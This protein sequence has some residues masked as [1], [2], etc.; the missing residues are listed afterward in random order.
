MSNSFWLNNPSILVDKKHIT[1]IWPSNDLNYTE[2]LNAITRCIIILAVL[3][4]LM[5]KSTKILVSSFITIFIIALVYKVQKHK[6]SKKKITKKLLKEGFTNIINY[7]NHNDKFKNPTGKNP[8][9]NVMLTEI[10][11]TPERP[12]AAPS[13]NRNI[14]KKINDSVKKNIDPKLFLDLGDS[15]GFDQSMRNFHTMP[16][17]KVCNDQ[18]AFAEYCY[19]NMPSCKEG[20]ESQCTKNNERYVLL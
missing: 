15:L 20:N 2:K 5:T 4:Y 12:P 19:G 16:N 3:G 11:D 18:R 8:M 6:I 1:K 7:E 13:F 14:E 10:D 9:M 17:T